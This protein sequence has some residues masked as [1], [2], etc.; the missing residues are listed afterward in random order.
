[1][2][3]RRDMS[4]EQWRQYL[5]E[6]NRLESRVLCICGNILMAYAFLCAVLTEMFSVVVLPWESI[7]L[8][9]LA[10]TIYEMF[11]CIRAY[12]EEEDMKKHEMKIIAIIIMVGIGMIMSIVKTDVATPVLILYPVLIVIGYCIRKAGKERLN[13]EK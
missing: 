5:A 13:E 12:L 7:C 8:V 3:R 11:F 9:A 10:G 6:R 2:M 1:M 4:P